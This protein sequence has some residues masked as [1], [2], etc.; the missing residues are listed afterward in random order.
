MLKQIDL[1]HTNDTETVALAG[2]IEKHLYELG[3]G[4]DH[5]ENAVLGFST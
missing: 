3:D 2:A 4:I 5:L 1:D